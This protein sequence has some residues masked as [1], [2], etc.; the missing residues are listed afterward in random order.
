MAPGIDGIDYQRHVPGWV[1]VESGELVGVAADGI[2]V[3]LG[4]VNL[5]GSL[6]ASTLSYL[7][8]NP[9]PENW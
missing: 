9:H 4:C 8:A 6:S 3:N 1:W 2:I 5:D 7:A